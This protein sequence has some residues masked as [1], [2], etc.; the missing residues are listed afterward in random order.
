[1]EGEG[2]PEKALRKRDGIPL[3]EVT[4]GELQTL[5]KDLGVPFAMGA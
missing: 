3:D 2:S 1:M 4:F 5:A